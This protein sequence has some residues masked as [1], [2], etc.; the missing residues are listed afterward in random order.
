MTQ[1]RNRP[2]QQPYPF[3]NV[4]MANH[5]NFLINLTKIFAEKYDSGIP[6]KIRLGIPILGNPVPYI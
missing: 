3:I 1:L 4:R 2:C 5:N 6:T